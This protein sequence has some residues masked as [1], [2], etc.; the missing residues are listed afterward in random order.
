MSLLTDSSLIGKQDF[1]ASYQKAR[2]EAFSINNIKSGWKAT[3]LW[4][5]SMAKPLM[6]PLLNSK[7]VKGIPKQALES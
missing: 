5:K 1:L 6:S 4:P 3:G 7:K 2:K